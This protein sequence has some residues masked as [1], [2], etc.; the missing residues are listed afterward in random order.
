MKKSFCYLMLSLFAAVAYA[1]TDYSL[2]DRMYRDAQAAENQAKPDYLDVIRK[3]TAVKKCNPNMEGNVDSHILAVFKKIETLRDVA[4]RN[5]ILAVI[6]ANEARESAK[7]ASEAEEKARNDE[8]AGRNAVTAL[9]VARTDPTIG[10]RMAEYVMN[11][12][13][14]NPVPAV[15]FSDIY[16]NKSNQ[17]YLK[18][19]RG[20]RTGPISSIAYSSHGTKLLLG[21][22]FF[23]ELWDLT[24]TEDQ[25][26]VVF[27]SPQENNE[28]WFFSQS[29]A[30]S[31]D[32]QWVLTSSIDTVKLWDINGH[33]TKWFVGH[34]KDISSV[35]FSP[36][37]N[38]LLTTSVDSTAKLWTLDGKALTTFKGHDG[39]VF[40][41]AFSPDS[42]TVLT[43]SEDGLAKLWSLDGTELATFRGHRG[44]VLS[45]AFSPDGKKV[46]TGSSD[47]SAIIWSIEGNRI[48][49]LIGHK[50]EVSAVA[51]SPD[52]KTILTGSYD[53]SAKLWTADGL[54]KSTFTGH[55]SQ[56]IDVAFSPDGDE[57]ATA[58]VD[59]TIKIWNT[60]TEKFDKAKAEQL[61]G[62][63]NNVIFKP[64]GPRILSGRS[65][66]QVFIST[67]GYGDFDVLLNDNNNEDNN[68]NENRL[69]T[70][71]ACSPDKTKVL[72]AWADTLK[73]W[74]IEGQL[75]QSI[76]DTG[77]VKSLVF[78]PNGSSFVA[79]KDDGKALIW[80]MNGHKLATLV[81]GDTSRILC[82]A[83][84]PDG[85]N[86]A[87]GANDHKIRIW[88][89]SGKLIHTNTGHTAAVITIAYS[90]DGEV[91]LTGS[92]DKTAILWS[93]DGKRSTPLKG[94]TGS[95]FKVAVS[96]D[97]TMMATLSYDNTM[98]LWGS[99]GAEISTMPYYYG[100]GVNA[101]FT[102]DSR[103]LVVVDVNQGVNF[104]TTPGFFI[105][106]HVMPVPLLQMV[107]NGLVLTDEEVIRS[108]EPDLLAYWGDKKF[109]QEEW[110]EAK[111]YYQ[112]AETICHTTNAMIGL[113]KISQKKSA[114]FDTKVFLQSNDP[115]ELLN[116]ADA[117]CPTT[118]ITR[119]IQKIDKLRELYSLAKQLEDRAFELDTVLF[120]QV[121][122]T[123]ADAYNSLGYNQLF[124]RDQIGPVASEWS[125]KRGLE[126]D[127]SHPY[128]LTNL[129]LAYLLQNRWAE[130]EKIYR[131][132][133]DLKCWPE[134]G[135]PLYKDAFLS[136][137]NEFKRRG[138]DHPDFAK[139]RAIMQEGQPTPPVDDNDPDD[140]K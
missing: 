46:L 64:A 50:S 71:V 25:K 8:R 65:N 114:D 72:T 129:P 96:P 116:Y 36:D 5:R 92:D 40:S 41:A 33:L 1:Q 89:S 120:R 19:I 13:P 130:A 84:S 61:A 70:V 17:Y 137:L 75:L 27:S 78:S 83:F 54:E 14:K 68:D 60:S 77:N 91:I 42:T 82:L 101:G 97:K 69:V 37:G 43:G 94:H 53:G 7:K 20:S 56:I 127:P 109:K 49:D 9:K 39:M 11:S 99:E 52:G 38:R 88:D 98:K 48:K 2:C 44:K 18:N 128:L 67:P 115:H 76:P 136:D 125:I 15:V 103:W 106:T 105:P 45:V 113:Y 110:D 66:G 118:D 90:S 24:Q 6:K 104:W 138:I 122:G 140:K 134:S 135:F 87:A 31:P 22:Y 117:F 62:D 51:F 131:E 3:Y 111:Q 74:T 34:S 30:I 21:G 85:K 59:G 63:F 107:Q 119:D 126:I 12:N 73:L 58:S 26:P 28:R 86:V 132:Q 16:D 95:V 79:V 139:V 32:D 123:L 124:I 100:G 10:L 112:K 133:K 57:V 4:D 47:N 35:N 108:R 81:T 80:D 102:C 93:A 23:A 29:A 121:R 55:Y